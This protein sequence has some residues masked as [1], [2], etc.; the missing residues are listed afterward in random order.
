MTGDDAVLRDLASRYVWWDSPEKVLA[1]RPRFLCQLL[2]LGTAEDVRTA[3]RIVG[4]DA[5]RDALRDAPP[6]VLDA[7]S[8]SYWH[9]VLFGHRA[10]P[11]PRRPLPS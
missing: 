7:R 6:G 4:D 11:R 8:W 3:R 1:R 9:L 2:Q 5:L 10:P